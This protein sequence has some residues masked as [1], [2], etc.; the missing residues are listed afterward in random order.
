[1][2]PKRSG[3]SGRYLKGLE[4]S[5]GE[6][7]VVGHVRPRVRLGDAEV[8]EELR[9][10]LGAHRAAAVRVNRELARLDAVSFAGLC[11]S[12]SA[13]VALS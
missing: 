9:Y 2:Q 6:W 5:F 11:V 1:M 10:E 12:F 4:A 8:R 7:V 3:K 13:S